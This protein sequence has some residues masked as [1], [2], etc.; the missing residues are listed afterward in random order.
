MLANNKGAA[1]LKAAIPR[2]GPLAGKLVAGESQKGY[3]ARRSCA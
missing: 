1:A 2:A 3:D